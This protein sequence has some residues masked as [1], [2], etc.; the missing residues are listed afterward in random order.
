[1][2]SIKRSLPAHCS[3]W[4]I[5]H[6]LPSLATITQNY[7]LCLT[8]LFLMLLSA[9]KKK[10]KQQS[11]P[12]ETLTETSRFFGVHRHISLAWTKPEYRCEISVE[13][14]STNLLCTFVAK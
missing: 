7:L 2:F 14:F 4:Y 9:R 12:T 3:A 10:A 6:P 11:Q 8:L 1:M 13:L 5:Q